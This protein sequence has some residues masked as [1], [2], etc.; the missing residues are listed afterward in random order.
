MSI[1]KRLVNK[2]AIVT[3]GASGI[4]A[5]TV[6]TFAAHGAAVVAADVQD[7]L[8]Q[9]LINEVTEA[10][11]EAIYRTLD[12]TDEEAWN[13][14]VDEIVNKYK[15]LDILG[16][17]AGVSGRDPQL[18]VQTTITP[19]P[20]I[21]DTTVDVWNR[22]MDVNV[23]GVYLGTKFAIPA[24]RAAG[25]GSIINI[26]SICGL[27]GSF[28]NAAYHASK[29]AVRIFSKATALQ[30]AGDKIRANSIHPGFI[31][32]PMTQPGHSNNEI[33]KIRMDA[34]P[35]G[36]FGVPAD[37]AM[38]CLYLASDESSYVTGSE[39]VIDGGVTAH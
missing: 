10:G 14:L 11:G 26:S 35:L 24:M 20:T 21:E 33:A 12:V 37:I 4:G 29:G 39:L 16:N 30:H 7:E 19:G 34:T 28:G 27:V 1:G 15:K 8:G 32:T 17:I 13:N 25:G 3:G 36:R 9:E 23:K 38:G 31:D 22:I 2:V 5:E 18:K 6:R